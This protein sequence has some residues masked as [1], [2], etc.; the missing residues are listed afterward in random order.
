[1]KTPMDA[2][3][4]AVFLVGLKSTGCHFGRGGATLSNRAQIAPFCSIFPELEFATGRK[5]LI[6][7][8]FLEPAIGLEPM[9]C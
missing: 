8:G 7:R 3:Q 1:M 2:A 5:S 4:N 6:C 9:T